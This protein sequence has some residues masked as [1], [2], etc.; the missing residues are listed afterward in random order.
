[1]FD[2]SILNFLIEGEIN[3]IIG[4]VG[5]VFCRRLD[6]IISFLFFNLLDIKQC[7]EKQFSLLSIDLSEQ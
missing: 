6:I 4:K 1:M 5:K 2:N 7:Y 3:F